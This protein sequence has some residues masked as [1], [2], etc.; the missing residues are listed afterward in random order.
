MALLISPTTPA[1]VTP[2]DKAVSSRRLRDAALWKRALA[3][4][5]ALKQGQHTVDDVTVTSAIV[6]IQGASYQAAQYVGKMLA[7][8]THAL[9]G[10]TLGDASDP[11]TV[12]AN[13]AP[14][15]AT[16]S[17][18]H[19]VFEAAFLGAPMWGVFI[20]E[21]KT[22]RELNGLLAIADVTDPEAPASS[23]RTYATPGERARAVF[24][25]QVHGGV[26]AQ[27]YGMDGEIRVAAVNGLTKRPALLARLLR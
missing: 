6:P 24:L 15:T 16:R 17:L 5:G 21:P 11:L 25:S 26:F 13:V 10:T 2:E 19:P 14:I 22:T 12:S 3:R 8:E 18:S 20:A 7:A 1:V 23:S 27:P 4:A 9:H